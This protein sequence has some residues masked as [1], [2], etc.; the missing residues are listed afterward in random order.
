MDILYTLGTGSIYQNAEIKMSIKLIRKYAKFDRIFVIGENP[1]IEGIEF[2]PFKDTMSRTRNVFRK[3][4]EVAENSDISEDFLYMMDDVFVL[5]PIDIENYL[6]YHSGEIPTYPN[7]SSYFRE[8][9]NTKEFLK[10]NKKPTLHYGVH[11][12]IIYNKK[13][14]LEIDPMYWQYVNRYNRELNPRILYGNWFEND[15]KQFIKDLKL[16]KDYPMQELKDMLKD[17]EWFSIGSR[18][19]DGNIKKY[20]EEL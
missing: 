16:I 8:I 10:Q 4:C 9:L 7:V 19:Y 20:L 6:L 1:N 14:I 18:S 3:L 11:C 12:P 2:I 15:N 13:K 5:R 17:K